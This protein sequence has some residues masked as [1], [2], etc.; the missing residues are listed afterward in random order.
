MVCARFPAPPALSIRDKYYTI[1]ALGTAGQTICTVAFSKLVPDPWGMT[2]LALGMIGGG[3]LE[4]PSGLWLDKHGGARGVS[5]SYKFYVFHG[6]FFAI[7]CLLGLGPQTGIA[8][9]SLKT[10]VIM[11]FCAEMALTIATAFEQTAIN[12][13]AISHLI[14]A[15]QDPLNVKLQSEKKFIT[16][17][18]RFLAGSF[19]L[20]PIV[21]TG[22][23][24]LCYL[25]S[26]SLFIGAYWLSTDMLSP[27]EVKATVEEAP[28]QPE[29]APRDRL[30]TTWSYFR[31]NPRLRHL[32]TIYCPFYLIGLIYL[33]YWERIFCN[34]NQVKNEAIFLP[35]MVWSFQSLAR[36][37]GSC[38][39]L[40]AKGNSQKAWALLRCG[41]IQVAMATLILPLSVLL[42]PKPLDARILNLI[43]L[44]SVGLLYVGLEMATPLYKGLIHDEVEDE[45]HRATMESIFDAGPAALIVFYS[46]FLLLGPG[47]HGAEVHFWGA[48]AVGCLLTLAIVWPGKLTV[49]EKTA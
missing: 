9:V 41:G 18:A 38:L 6:I 33:Y 27:V 25:I 13:W 1:S 48:A 31:A 17:I 44:M 16:N 14:S 26:T 19:V 46:A 28:A 12:K 22:H 29:I 42:M 8:T 43:V 2:I 21:T 10:G 30:Q 32:F 36:I 35:I 23:L 49:V 5:L 39:A 37:Q 11:V 34:F 47:T 24:L 40:K 20:L 7:A 15:G 3:V 45:S 4:I